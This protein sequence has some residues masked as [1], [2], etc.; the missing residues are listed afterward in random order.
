MKPQTFE[1]LE[2]RRLMSAAAGTAPAPIADAFLF[3]DNVRRD[4]AGNAGE[5]RSYDGSGNNVD[6][7]LWGAVDATFLRLADAEYADGLAAPAGAE[8]PSARAVSNAVAD[9]GESDVSSGSFMSAFVYAWGQFLDHDLTLTHNGG[10]TLSIAVPADDEHFLPGSTID[11]TRSLAVVD[12]DGVSQQFNAITAFIDGSMVYGS[13]QETANS[14][15]AFEGGRMLTSDGDL[16]PVGA[17]G[18]FEAGDIR[19]NENPNLTAL[20]TLFVREHNRLADEAAARHPGWSDERLFQHARRI[21]IGEIQHITYSE[22]LPTLLGDRAIGRYEGYDP[23]VNA[24]ISNEFATAAF[25][26]G[27]SL[28]ENTIEFLDNSGDAVADA[29]GLAEAFFNPGLVSELGIGPMLKYLASSNANELDTRVVD[30]LRNF[31]FGPPGAGGL[32]LAALNIERGRDHGLADYN[33]TREALGLPRVTRFDQITS[34]ADIAATLESLYGSVDDIDL[35]VGGLAEDHAR[36]ANVGETFGA[37]LV[38]QFTR[39]RDGD[40][41]WYERDLGRRELGFVRRT[42]LADLIA[43][44]TEIDNLQR[45]VFTFNAGVSGS[46]FADVNG[47]RDGRPLAGVPVQLLD[48]DDV[49][50]GVARTDRR[51]VFHFD[52]LAL[53]DYRTV[54][55]LPDGS[56]SAFALKFDVTRGGDLRGGSIELALADRDRPDRPRHA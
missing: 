56:A 38:D 10:D 39:T 41:F 51:G 26:F 13:S 45:G 11:T 53:G 14:L 6:N 36:G 9:A 55:L 15:R 16:L 28:V 35:W 19:A 48:A 8:R 18:F 22:F 37:I 50:I 30:S 43:A 24:G 52:G 12:G 31:L 32:D 27:H 17:S 1:A 25:R 2:P 47:P 23:G 49:V 46:V 29:V 40:R 42:T 33:D 21:V 34:D 5:I 7:P 3:A 4:G 54:A 20:Q 44:N